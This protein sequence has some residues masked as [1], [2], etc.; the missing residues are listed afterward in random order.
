MRRR[1]GP[2]SPIAI[3]SLCCI[4]LLI[5]GYRQQRVSPRSPP[6]WAPGLGGGPQV[7]V[8][9]GLH[10][11]R[12]SCWR[13]DGVAVLLSPP[14][15]AAAGG[16]GADRVDERL[17]HVQPGLHVLRVGAVHVGGP[18]AFIGRCLL[19][20]RGWGLLLRVPAGLRSTLV[21]HRSS[22]GPSAVLVWELGSWPLAG[23]ARSVYPCMRSSNSCRAASS[24]EDSA[25]K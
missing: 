15:F 5:S 24:S 17:R 19:R 25:A 16:I 6:P 23:V 3:S 18:G 13:R 14:V 21:A 7:N 4:A 1:S 22:T 8:G 12:L 9:Q 11:P 20:G 10:L 2:I